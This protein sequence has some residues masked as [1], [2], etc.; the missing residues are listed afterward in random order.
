MIERSRLAAVL[1][2]MPACVWVCDA[3][4]N[5]LSQSADAAEAQGFRLEELDEPLNVSERHEPH[6][7]LYREDGEPV[8]PGQAPA[9]R[10]LRGEAF[11]DEEIHWKNAPGSGFTPSARFQWKMRSARRSARWW[12]RWT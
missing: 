5:L 10:A 11:R 4:G 7:Q 2:H 3:D 6:Y 9:V 8:R 12:W 1:D